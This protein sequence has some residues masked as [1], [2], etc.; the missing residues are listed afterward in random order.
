MVRRQAESASGATEIDDS[1]EFPITVTPAMQEKHSA[2]SPS[3]SN[4]PCINAINP[5]A[6]QKVTTTDLTRGTP[7]TTTLDPHIFQQ[8]SPIWNAGH[9]RAF[10]SASAHSRQLKERMMGIACWLWAKRNDHQCP[11]MLR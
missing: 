2:K 9:Q 3:M 6:I 1:P 5:K 10:I 7:V 8:I 11:Q 4:G